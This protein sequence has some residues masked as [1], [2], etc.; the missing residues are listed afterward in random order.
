MKWEGRVQNL[1]LK[2]IPE[3]ILLVTFL[4]I[5][6]LFHILTPIDVWHQ[7]FGHIGKDKIIKTSKLKCVRRL[8]RLK[9]SSKECQFCKVSKQRRISFKLIE[10]CKSSHP[11]KR[12]FLDVW[13][14]ILDIGGNGEKY[15][16][17]IIDEFS[18]K[19]AIYPMKRK[20]F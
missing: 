17:S 8:P 16:L 7:K 13:G 5:Y 2:T 15:F 10:G 3:L 12:L 9:N 11:L 1:K 4:R 20:T 19:T 14:P 18:C 6:P